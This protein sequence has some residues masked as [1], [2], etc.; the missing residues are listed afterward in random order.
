MLCDNIIQ[1]FNHFCTTC[2]K[3]THHGDIVR[4]R[5]YISSPKLLT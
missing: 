1:L 3:W 5:L 4:V 2:G